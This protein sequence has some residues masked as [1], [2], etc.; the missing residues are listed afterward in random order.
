MGRSRQPVDWIQASGSNSTGRF[1]SQYVGNAASYLGN[2]Q[3]PNGWG[4]G[5]VGSGTNLNIGQV[6]SSDG[7][8]IMD[9]MTLHVLGGMSVSGQT[10]ISGT[11]A[12]LGNTPIY[13]QNGSPI[14]HIFGVSAQMDP[15]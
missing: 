4:I 3:A 2:W 1:K 15:R 7:S 13:C 6:S 14:Q 11:L 9:G 5:G 10:A 12:H 8:W